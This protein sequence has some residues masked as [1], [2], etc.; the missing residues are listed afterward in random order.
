MVL[1]ALWSCALELKD[2]PGPPQF[3][4][5]GVWF[6]AGNDDHSGI[7]LTIDEGSGE[8]GASFNFRELQILQRN[9]LISGKMA[10]ITWRT[11]SVRT[12]AEEVLL[13]Q[14]QF[15]TLRQRHT[16]KEPSEVWP[17]QGYGP[18]DLDREVS[19]GTGLRLLRFADGGRTLVGKGLTFR[20]VG[21]DPNRRPVGVV[22]LI[23]RANARALIVVPGRAVP[24]GIVTGPS[25]TAV[26]L[27]GREGE[28]FT[29]AAGPSL[30]VG[31]A[32]YRGGTEA[33]GAKQLTKAEVLQRL[34]R[35]QKVP[36]EDL[37]RVLGPQAGGKR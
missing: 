29:I 5:V 13:F 19:G 31:Q 18:L 21:S 2:P 26:P 1:A 35:G 25:G 27:L 9:L 4:P 20:R 33:K 12:S 15:R 34:Q 28:R 14:E 17:G 24:D 37:I 6:S 16:S 3:S 32:V 11:G 36:R 7:A 10:F 8:G 30:A 22:I 23:D